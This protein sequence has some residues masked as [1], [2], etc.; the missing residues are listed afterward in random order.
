VRLKS[1]QA[2]HRK[3]RSVLRYFTV[4]REPMGGAV[5]LVSI[6]FF[7]TEN[8]FPIIDTASRHGY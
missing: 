6:V 7:E 4:K 2:S 3:D 1:R 8:G 5:S